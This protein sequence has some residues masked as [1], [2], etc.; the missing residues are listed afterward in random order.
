MIL[1]TIILLSAGFLFASPSWIGVQGTGSYQQ[2][3][4][5]IGS[6]DQKNTV[7]LGGL[8]IAGTIYPGKSPLG[9]GF[10]LGASK[11]MKVTRGSIEIDI[12]DY[13]LTW[14]GVARATYRA[15]MTKMLALEL[16]AGLMY[17]RMTRTYDFGGNDAEATLNTLSVSTSADMIIH[18]SDGLSLVAGVGASFPLSAQGEY[19]LLGISYDTDFEVKGYTFN[20]QVGVAFGF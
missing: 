6:A 19:K 17:S 15:D 9:I 7:T 3:T 18:L 10:Q 13:P 1:C 8:H 2:D 16:G 14:N 12:D 5:D 20:G 11:T 4:T